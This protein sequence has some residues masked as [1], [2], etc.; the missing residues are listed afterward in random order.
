MAKNGGLSLFSKKEKRFIF[1]GRHSASDKLVNGE[2]SAFTEE[3]ARKKLAKRGIRP[4]QITRVKTS[5]KRKITQED[6]T[7]F[8]RQL[9]TM[10]KAGLPLMQAFE[11]VA[12]GHGNPSMT[13][14]LMEIRGEV[15]QGSSLSRAFSNHPKYF[16]RFY[17]NLVAAGETG[18]VLE[19]LLDK[20]AIYKEKTQA[21]RKK[22]K[23]AL[24]YPVSVIAVAIG[25]V[26]VMMIFVLPAFKEVY[27]NMGAELPALTQTVMDMSDFFVSYGWMVLIALGFAIYGFL[28]LK[29]RSI[30]I[31]RRMDAILLRMPIFGDIVRK[32]TIARWG[33]TTATLIAAGVPLVD[34]LDSTAGAA[35]NLIYEEATR[36]IRTRVIQGLSMTSGMRATELFPNMMLQMSSIGEESGSL[37][38]ML[39]K[40]A[41]FYEDEVDNA[42]GRLSAMMEPIIIVI[43][44]LVI[45]TLLVAMY[46]PLFN[47]GNV[48]A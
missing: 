25:L 47:L 16:D 1:E 43:L 41:E 42:V 27:A 7:V 21:I 33:R 38:D 35:G 29:A 45:G 26:F 28:K 32:G 36:E 3:E 14:M 30:K 23:T 40:A 15:E 34:V 17:C 46:L 9:S 18:G 4:L 6:I 12:R 37:D 2:V 5:S 20:L 48:V 19:S 39:N 10:I 13:E 22:V 44:G 11:I 8:T 24:T 31:Q